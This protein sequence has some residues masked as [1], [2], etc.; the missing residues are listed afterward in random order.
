MSVFLMFDQW[1]NFP[2]EAQCLFP[3]F[4]EHCAISLILLDKTVPVIW[5]TV[6]FSGILVCVCIVWTDPKTFALQIGHTFLEKYRHFIYEYMDVIYFWTSVKNIPVQSAMVERLCACGLLHTICHVHSEHI[7]LYGPDCPNIQDH[8]E[9]MKSFHSDKMYLS[10]TSVFL[11]H[12]IPLSFTTSF[13]C[14]L[15]SWRLWAL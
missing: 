12:W 1:N 3:L 11:H 6:K 14:I 15:L 2:S 13:W 5:A 7:L 4:S 8:L 10:S 9:K